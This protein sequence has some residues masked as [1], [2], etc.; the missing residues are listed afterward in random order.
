MKSKTPPAAAVDED[1]AE[2]EEDDEEFMKEI[3]DLST[4]REETSFL[5]HEDGLG[6]RLP[7]NEHFKPYPLKCGSYIVGISTVSQKITRKYKN[8]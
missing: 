4:W 2:V 5:I 8:L 1:N 7:I 3:M 6:K